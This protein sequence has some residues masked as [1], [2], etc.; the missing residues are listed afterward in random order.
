[1]GFYYKQAHYLP[2]AG[3]DELSKRGPS[4]N[5]SGLCYIILPFVVQSIKL[6]TNNEVIY[7]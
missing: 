6:L 1:M 7:V 4:R 2:I 5:I 3:T